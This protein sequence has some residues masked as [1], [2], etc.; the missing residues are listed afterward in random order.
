MDIQVK[1]FLVSVLPT[2]TKRQATWERTRFLFGWPISRKRVLLIGCLR[3]TLRKSESEGL[4]R[5]HRKS[6]EEF[7]LIQETETVF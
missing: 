6:S 2:N 1:K 3:K 4:A 7:P 5:T